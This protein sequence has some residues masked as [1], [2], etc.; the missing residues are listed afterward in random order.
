MNN[1]NNTLKHLNFFVDVSVDAKKK[2]KAF[3]E[4]SSSKG[5]TIR[6]FFVM[7]NGNVKKR[8]EWLLFFQKKFFFVFRK[9]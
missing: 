3:F 8:S 9:K 5:L 2:L 6:I 4:R 1:H 7:F